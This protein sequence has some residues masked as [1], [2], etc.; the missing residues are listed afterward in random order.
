MYS[1]QLVGHF[2]KLHCLFNMICYYRPQYLKTSC[3]PI[4]SL[5]FQR[6]ITKIILLPFHKLRQEVCVTCVAYNHFMVLGML[7]YILNLSCY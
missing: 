5:P 6:I 1:H 3:L 2:Y 7:L 4:S